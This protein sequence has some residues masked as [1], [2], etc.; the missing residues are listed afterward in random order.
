MNRTRTK[1]AGK[2]DRP[3]GAGWKSGTLALALSAGAGAVLILI[4]S[5]AANF[6][7]D[8]GRMIRPLAVAAAALTYLFAGWIAAKLRPDAPLAAGTVNG[9]ILSAISLA[10]SL[11]FRK[12]A[13]A[14][15]AYA[16]ALIHAGMILLSLL[17]AY[18]YLL[19][20]RKPKKKKRKRG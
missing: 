16:A 9:L 7:P 13:T 18:L 2:T 1:K 20:E 11:C 15:P 5:A 10:L 19:K 8:P 12:T 3:A 14:L 6:T 17:G 4:A